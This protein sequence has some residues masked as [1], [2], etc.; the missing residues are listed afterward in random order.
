[1]N[2][3][4]LK[5][6]VIIAETGSVTRAAERLMV[7]QPSLSRQLR[8]LEKAFGGPL[9]IRAGR[10]LTLTPLGQVVLARAQ[11]VLQEVEALSQVAYHAPERR[12]VSLGASLTTLSGFLPRAVSQFRAVH[13]D[14]ELSVRTGLSQDVYDLVGQGAVEVGVVSAP[15]ARPI[16]VTE[17]LFT[18]TLWLIAPAHHPLAQREAVFPHDLDA[19]AMVTMT[20]RA[21]LRQDLNAL[22]STF[23]VQPRI[24]MEIDN[25][26]VLQ[27]MV[28]VGLGVTVLPRS[29]YIP[30]LHDQQLV[31]IPF[32]VPEGYESLLP[33]RRF[34]LIYLPAPLSPLAQAWVEVCQSVAAEYWAR[35][36]QP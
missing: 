18:D 7:A 5:H 31:A 33:T 6:F 1:M 35:R 2:L 32:E 15:Q 27:A 28:A 4:A 3:E 8:Q 10:H 17:P 16:I 25:V 26:G 23:H 11:K 24:S 14:V 13:P 34:A 36:P 19:V 29:A 9:F 22:W 20:P 12:Q 21:A 30:Y